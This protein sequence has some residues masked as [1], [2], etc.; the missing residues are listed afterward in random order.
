L[1]AGWLVDL[2]QVLGLLKCLAELL[3]GE[4]FMGLYVP[5]GTCASNRDADRGGTVASKIGC[6]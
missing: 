4:Q 5:E 2:R 1:L 3:L 6:K